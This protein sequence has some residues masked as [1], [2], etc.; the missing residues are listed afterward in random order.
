M[1][2]LGDVDQNLGFV[3]LNFAGLEPVFE[4]CS[5]SALPPFCSYHN[6]INQ[7]TNDGYIVTEFYPHVPWASTHNTIPCAAGHHIHEGRWI[8]DPTVMRDCKSPVYFQ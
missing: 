1:R 4:A 2:G 8:R 5:N 7:T 3:T 6:H